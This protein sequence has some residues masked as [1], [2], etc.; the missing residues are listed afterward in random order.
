MIKVWGDTQSGNCYKV[1]LL[2][3]QTGSHY[4]W[5]HIDIVAGE[6]RTAEFLAMNPNGKIPLVELDNGD[7]LAESNAIL[8]YFSENTPLRPK[9]REVETAILQWMFF[10]QYSHEPNIATSRYWIKYCGGGAEYT[11][12]LK[13]KQPKGYAALD[14]M[15]QHLAA[16]DYL[17]GD[18]YSIADIS[19]YAYTHV[20]KEGG[21]S[22]NNYP[23][24]QQWLARVASQPNYIPMS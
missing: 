24:I 1:K 3:E 23:A 22:L 16:S 9:G 19:L 18:H 2:L 5:Q 17:V 7:L 4:Q 20:A 21:F 8:W 13:E 14:I 15:E 11:E 10:E 12:R 6:S